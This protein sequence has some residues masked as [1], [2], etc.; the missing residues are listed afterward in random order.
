MRPPI[1][2]KFPVWRPECAILPSGQVVHKSYLTYV[3]PVLFAEIYGTDTLNKFE[4]DLLNSGY[5]R[6]AE[7]TTEIIN[8]IK[9]G[10]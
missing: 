7:I 10:V 1:R 6:V 8:K 4:Q 5:I 3:D 2:R 9:N